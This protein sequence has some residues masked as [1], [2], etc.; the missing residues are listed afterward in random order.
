MTKLTHAEMHL[1]HKQW[2]SELDIWL[3]DTA[4]WHTQYQNALS[5][6]KEIE[7]VIENP[8]TKRIQRV[9]KDHDRALEH[10]KELIELYQEEIKLHDKGIVDHMHMSADEEYISH[11]RLVNSH[12]DYRKKQAIQREVHER[13]KNDY[14]EI[15]TELAILKKQIENSL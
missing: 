2:Q 12:L 1:D 14:H 8:G 11:D 4:A 13:I 3:K 9:I 6:L 5:E 7:R 15:M 10:H